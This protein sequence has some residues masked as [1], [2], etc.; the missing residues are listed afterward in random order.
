MRDKQF[1]LIW[2]QDWFDSNY[3]KVR[4]E[5]TTLD[6]PGWFL[7]VALPGEKKDIY[8]NDKSEEDWISSTQRDEVIFDGAGGANNLSELISIFALWIHKKEIKEADFLPEHDLLNWIQRWFASNCDGDWEHGYG[9]KINGLLGRG[10]D[11]SINL[12][13]TIYQN[14]KFAFKRE[15]KSEDDYY[16]VGTNQGKLIG[17][18]GRKNLI[19]ILSEFKDWITAQELDEDIADDLSLEKY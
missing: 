15:Y 14:K 17:N 3:D 5:I 9:I 12:L 16:R 8:C 10:W 7:E 11:V 18:G 4:I 1:D 6:N 13:D 2:L 19:D